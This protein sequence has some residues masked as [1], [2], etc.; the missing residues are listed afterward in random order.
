MKEKVDKAKE[1]LP[2]TCIIGGTFVPL[3]LSL[4]GGFTEIGYVPKSRVIFKKN[5]MFGYGCGVSQYNKFYD[6]DLD[7]YQVLPRPYIGSFDGFPGDKFIKKWVLDLAD[8]A[9]FS[10]GIY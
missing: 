3:L 2:S 4:I 5:P 6:R 10:P 7:M 8:Q 9:N 1:I